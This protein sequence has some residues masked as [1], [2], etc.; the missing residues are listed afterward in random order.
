MKLS[1]FKFKLPQEKIAQYPSDYDPTTGIYHR[2]ECKMMVV[3]KKTGEIEH[4]TFK[5]II[6]YFERTFL[7][8]MTQKYSLLASGV[9]RKK[10]VHELRF[11]SYGSLTKTSAFGMCL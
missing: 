2:D 8:L 9:T 10:P 3:H 4:R 11:F 6:E 1:Q 5:N 7:S